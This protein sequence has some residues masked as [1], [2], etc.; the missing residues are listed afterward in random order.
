MY[1]TEAMDQLTRDNA[2]AA[3]RSGEEV[4]KIPT[5]APGV[6]VE[7]CGLDEARIRRLAG[8]APR[9][10]G[11]LGPDASAPQEARELV[12]VLALL[13]PTSMPREGGCGAQ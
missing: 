11:R 7:E 5:S 4:V 8:E 9:V 12:E 2:G 10:I 3:D 1:R 6:S 13:K